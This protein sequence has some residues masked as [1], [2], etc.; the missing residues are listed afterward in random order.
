MYFSLAKM[1]LTRPQVVIV[2]CFMVQLTMTNSLRILGIFHTRAL[3]HFFIGDALMKG[4]SEAGH[5]VTAISMFPL[6]KKFDN[7]QHINITGA[8]QHVKANTNNYLDKYDLGFFRNLIRFFK[9][10]IETTNATFYHPAVQRFM[11][12]KGEHFDLVITE[13]F[14]SEAL[15]GFGQHFKA[16]VITVGTFGTVKWLDDLVG[17]ASPASYV[18]HPFLSF[19]DK[20]DFR[21]RVINTI[22]IIFE[23]FLMEFIYLPQQNEMYDKVFADPKPSLA[24]LRKNV[25]LV[26]VNSHFTY[27]HPR[28]FVPNMIEI[29]G[30]QV[31]RQ[32]SALPDDV[33]IVLDS[34][35][36]GAIYF[37]MGTHIKSSELPLN[38]KNDILKVLSKLK[39]R[40]LWKWEDANLT[41][42]FDNVFVK[43]WFPQQS[44]LAHP[45][46]KCFITHGGLLSTSEAVYH[47]VPVIG[48]PVFG[49][50][51]LN[52][53][54]AQAHGYA[55]LLSYSNLTEQS[56]EW[57]V[58]E[59]LTNLRY[60][61]L[62]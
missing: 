55:I 28:P 47:G 6:S 13:I 46:I 51:H 34:A 35:V 27:K 38:K 53:A 15:I 17:N 14:G 23:Y 7:F 3:S 24:D 56:F 37:S 32:S 22:A 29:G 40:V 58:N 2:T 30:I 1:M 26:L 52:M 43:S 11:T 25:S 48:I 19:T 57:A 60:I 59:I 4:L 42:K 16:P 61:L 5:D 49:D 21:Q 33:Q 36:D 54:T 8:D 31:N 44:I 62:L 20:M 39:Q 41:G 45:N 10:G 12:D 9:R 18:P 50:Q